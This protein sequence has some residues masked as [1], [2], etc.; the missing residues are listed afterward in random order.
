VLS[1]SS[2]EWGRSSAQLLVGTALS[3][4]L[5]LV[6]YYLWLKPMVEGQP[7][8]SS[9]A[10]STVAFA[11]VFAAI[12][13]A[14]TRVQTAIQNGSDAYVV[15]NW[16]PALAAVGAE[17]LV[18]TAFFATRNWKPI[19][20]SSVIGGDGTVSG[21][22]SQPFLLFGTIALVPAVTTLLIHLMKAP[23]VFEGRLSTAG[24]L[25]HYAPGEGLT[26]G[27]PSLAPF[28]GSR[29]T[30]AQLSLFSGTL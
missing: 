15:D 16:A 11:A 9:T 26:A 8:F 14:V 3:A 17:A 7:M 12:P 28:A 23:R 4:G 19:G 2:I 10:L 13:L 22:G 30:G 20:D 18:M 27:L 6:P 25:L 29:G 24:S 1:A 21:E 5:T